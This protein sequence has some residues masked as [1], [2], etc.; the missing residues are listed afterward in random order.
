MKKTTFLILILLS[1]LSCNKKDDPQPTSNNNNGTTTP[2]IT[3]TNTPPALQPNLSYTAT[4]ATQL[5]ID[6]SS[7]ITDSENDTWSIITATANH[8]FAII[9]GTTINYTSTTSYIGNDTITVSIKDSKGAT[10]R[11]KI[12]I[13]VNSSNPSNHIPSVNPPSKMILDE[14]QW[15]GNTYGYAIYIKA[16][17]SYASFNATDADND[18]VAITNIDGYSSNIKSIQGIATNLSADDIANGNFSGNIN[19]I[20]YNR[21]YSGVETLNITFSDGK[22]TITKTYT[23]Q[24]GSDAKLQATTIL[25]NFMNTG[26]MGNGLGSGTFWGTLTINPNGNLTTTM[27]QPQGN[28]SG[29][30]TSPGTYS[31]SI[32]DDGWMVISIT[33]NNS[34][35]TSSYA[36][37]KYIYNNDTYLKLTNVDTQI[38]YSFK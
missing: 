26:L 32:N 21:I 1:I 13:I 29:Y 14:E 37:D 3:T 38:I 9:S 7:K 20:P 12:A 10:S 34:T 5:S 18:N 6:L 31:Y 28:F 16:Y 2:P 25:N 22:S 17:S 35:T 8:G 36:V 27:T 19:I 33:M 11:G 30:Q 15:L 23:I 4:T 24:L